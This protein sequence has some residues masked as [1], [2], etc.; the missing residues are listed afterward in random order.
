M[1][2]AVE[3]RIVKAGEQF[4]G[5][6]GTVEVATGADAGRM[7]AVIV[8]SAAYPENACHE[9]RIRD[10]ETRVKSLETRVLLGGERS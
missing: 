7:E 9:G 8:G 5:R 2:Y 3:C 10:L 4:I 6:C 1:I